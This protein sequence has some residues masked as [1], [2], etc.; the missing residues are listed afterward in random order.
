MCKGTFISE[1]NALGML[2]QVHAS[3]GTQE[4]AEFLHKPVGTNKIEWMTKDALY[5]VFRVSKRI[6]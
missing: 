5:F 3:P 6:I 1:K 4:S 2:E